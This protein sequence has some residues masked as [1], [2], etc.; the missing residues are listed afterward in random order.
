MHS[1]LRCEA[2]LVIRGHDYGG[3]FFQAGLPQR[4]PLSSFLFVLC[5]DPLLSALKRSTG[6]CAASGFVDDWAT[7]IAASDWNQAA[8]RLDKLLEVVEEFE[9][10]SGSRMNR[11]KSAV[12]PSRRLCP[13]EE[14]GCRRRWADLRVSY[15]ERLLGLYIGLEATLEDQYRVPLTKFDKVLAEYE[16]GRSKLSLAARIVV[17]NVFLQSLF[18]FQNRHFMMPRDLVR[19]VQSKILKFLTRMPW[20]KLGMF[21]HMHVIYGIRTRLQD[22]QLMNV[23]MLISSYYGQREAMASVINSLSILR[24]SPGV[25]GQGHRGLH[26]RHP[27]SNFLK[28]YELFRILSGMFPEEVLADLNEV[29]S[30]RESSARPLYNGMLSRTTAAWREYLKQRLAARGWDGDACV[31]S[32]L[33]LPRRMAQAHRWDLFRLH[34]NGH[35]TVSRLARAGVQVQ[36][37]ASCAL[38]NGGADSMDHIVGCPVTTEAWRQLSLTVDVPLGAFSMEALFLQDQREDVARSWCVAFFSAVMD[39]HKQL[40]RR[41]RDDAVASIVALILRS[42]QHPWTS[43]AL[44]SLSRQERRN[45]RARPP[46]W[47]GQCVVYRSNGRLVRTGGP[48]DCEACWGAAHWSDEGVLMESMHDSATRPATA[49][50]AKYLA[51]LACLC[52]ALER[53]AQDRHVM[54]EVSSLC[55]AWQV[56]HYGMGRHACR[57]PTLQPIFLRCIE[58]GRQLH[59]DGVEWSVRHI[60]TEYNEVA[61]ALAARGASRTGWQST[62]SQRP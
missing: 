28:A 38:C 6:V 57:S 9:R 56:Q 17:V 37:P 47:P 54:F 62:M 7:A 24:A 18:S 25:G 10:S 3:L 31:Q 36:R 12:V 34:L 44:P 8:D 32:L 26:Q 45:A 49:N 30:G 61:N 20:V 60:Y 4:C 52:R 51:L 15:F 22:L 11:G 53:R 46:Q 5:V 55:V 41:H 19:Q 39:A 42:L 23:S 13:Q 35:C 48:G 21:C 14:L 27:A 1:M 29:G 33:Y 50:V 16:I 43:C 2:R 40:S 58:V 59:A